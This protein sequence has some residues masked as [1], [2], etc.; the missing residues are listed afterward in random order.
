NKG[1][2]TVKTTKITFA[3]E[4]LESIFFRSKG[5]S[6]LSNITGEEINVGHMEV[7][8]TAK[9]LSDQEKE[10]IRKKVFVI[11]ERLHMRNTGIL[12]MEFLGNTVFIPVIE[13]EVDFYTEDWGR[14]GKTTGVHIETNALLG[15][16]SP[17][18]KDA[19]EIKQN[20]GE[21]I[22]Q[23]EP[24]VKV[25][26]RYKKLLFKEDIEYEEHLEQRESKEKP[27]KEHQEL[28]EEDFWLQDGGGSLYDAWWNRFLE[29]RD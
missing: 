28:F 25:F 14:F 3:A 9:C 17:V 23:K 1:K 13:I 26:S 18:I 20:I 22:T 21:M 29:R 16:I 24:V 27:I 15:K 8:D 7:M 19:G 10:A 5:L 6:V 12:F 4:E 2:E 11:R